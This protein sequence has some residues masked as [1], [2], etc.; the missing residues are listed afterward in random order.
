MTRTIFLYSLSLAGLVIVLKLLEYRFLVRVLPLEIYLGTVAVLFTA[1]GIWAGRKLTRTKTVV[2]HESDFQFDPALL[3][4]VG[5]SKRE[6]EVLGLMAQGLSNQEI[7]DALFVSLNT[8]KTHSS[9][10]FLKLDTKRRTQAIQKAKNLRLI[11]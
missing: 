8:I 10:L 7:A 5:I 9:N 11:P 6:Y 4:K 3:A 1:L 2:V